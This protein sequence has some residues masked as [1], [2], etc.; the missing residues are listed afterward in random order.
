MGRQ[1]LMQAICPRIGAIS[2]LGAV[3]RGC[4]AF[5]QEVR[6][7]APLISEGDHPEEGTA[8]DQGLM[9]HACVG[10]HHQAQGCFWKPFPGPAQLSQ[11][12]GKFRRPSGGYTFFSSGFYT[13]LG[14]DFMS[15]NRGDKA[16]PLPQSN[17]SA[18]K[19]SHLI[20]PI[21][22]DRHSSCKYLN[23]QSTP[24]PSPALHP[25]KQTEVKSCSGS[26]SREMARMGPLPATLAPNPFD[27]ITAHAL[28]QMFYFWG[29]GGVG[30]KGTRN[31]EIRTS[32]IPGLF[33]HHHR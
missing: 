24:P 10:R 29:G 1:L 12:A 7:W 32:F 31:N 3:P 21:S 8:M 13:V 26:E 2:S 6:R 28:H 11:W 19:N 22:S 30:R 9:T 14:G 20:L 17:T 25:P 5:R 16:K 23:R 33:H 18:L 4:P 27:L 15:G